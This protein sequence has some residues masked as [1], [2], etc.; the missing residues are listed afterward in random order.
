M[1]EEFISDDVIADFPQF[2]ARC[3]SV[4]KQQAP[5][6]WQCYT[7]TDMDIVYILDVTGVPRVRVSVSVYN[8]MSMCVHVNGETI[9]LSWL[10]GSMCEGKWKLT[11]WSQ[12]E[13]LLSVHGPADSSSINK[14]DSCKNLIDKA[15][16]LLTTVLEKSDAGN[17]HI[18]AVSFCLEQLR[19]CYVSKNARRY[20]SNLLSFAFTLY[21]RS[22]DCYKI[23]LNCNTFI[24]PHTIIAL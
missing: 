13:N 8:D 1:L 16:Q 11:Q 5:F 4:L 17:V 10:C 6:V 24:L 22:S 14:D 7:G 15:C 3:C 19:L 23:L 9:N 20:S 18:G 21:I 12:F 2:T